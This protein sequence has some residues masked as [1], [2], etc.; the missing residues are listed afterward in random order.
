MAKTGFQRRYE[1][2]LEN[3][4][5]RKGIT[6]GTTIFSQMNARAEAAI[7]EWQDLRE[8]GRRIK[9]HALANLDYYLEELERNFSAQG[10]NVFWARDAQSARD[11]VLEL[12]RSRKVK[13]AVKYSYTIM[14]LIAKMLKKISLTVDL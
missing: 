3:A 14:T 11:Y 7:P 8:E 5:L 10:G 2:V 13:T 9:N 12:A 6:L 1:A 4:K